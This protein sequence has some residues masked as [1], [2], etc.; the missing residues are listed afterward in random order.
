MSKVLRIVPVY[1]KCHISVCQIKKKK[2]E[3]NVSI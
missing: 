3:T 2:K 1:I